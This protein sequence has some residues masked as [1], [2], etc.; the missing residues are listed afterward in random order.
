M[1]KLTAAEEDVVS[2]TDEDSSNSS[3]SSIE[4][5]T[6][7]QSVSASSSP[8]GTLR[9]SAKAVLTC[10]PNSHPFQVEKREGWG[11]YFTWG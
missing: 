9:M 6:I 4:N 2:D 5:L 7:L 3:S 8:Q 11:V 10:R 1:R